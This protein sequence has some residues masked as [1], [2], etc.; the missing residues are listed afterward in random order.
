MTMVT[1]GMELILLLWFILFRK[2]KRGIPMNREERVLA[3]LIA[4][5]SIVYAVIEI[6]LYCNITPSILASYL[7]N[8]ACTILF[9][10]GILIISITATM[11][12]RR[13]ERIEKSL[14]KRS[15]ENLERKIRKELENVATTKNLT[16]PHQLRNDV[17]SKLAERVSYDI[18]NA[19]TTI[20]Y[21]V[22]RMDD[23]VGDVDIYL[24]GHILAIPLS[25]AKVLADKMIEL[26]KEPRYRKRSKWLSLFGV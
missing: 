19:S 10:L 22:Q 25:E 8:I 21:S 12:I 16:F 5:S 14:A 4:V 23:R 7:S 1:V 2:A 26:S 18:M 13:K 15:Y 11:I 9:V 6:L 3:W 24:G 20:D 17:I